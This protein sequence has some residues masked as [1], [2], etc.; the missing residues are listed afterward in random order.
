[1]FKG[2]T[3]LMQREKFKSN[4]TMPDVYVIS[5]EANIYVDDIE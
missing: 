5:I 2:S 4:Q 1:M 3:A